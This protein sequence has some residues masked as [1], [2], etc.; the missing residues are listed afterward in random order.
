MMESDDQ[1]LI[2]IK[3]LWCL[4]HIKETYNYLKPNQN[5]IVPLK[6]LNI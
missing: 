4:Q 1:K 5:Q 6:E 2:H 3:T